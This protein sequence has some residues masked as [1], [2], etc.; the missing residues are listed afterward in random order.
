M[1]DLNPQNNSDHYKNWTLKG[2][3]IKISIVGP[4]TKH[5]HNKSKDTEVRS[6][7]PSDVYCDTMLP[8]YL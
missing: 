1:T 6:F 4:I 3:N 7:Q 2:K 8:V 5:E